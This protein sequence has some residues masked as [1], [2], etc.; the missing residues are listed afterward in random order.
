MRKVHDRVVIANR[1]HPPHK[2]ALRR[3]RFL[4]CERRPKVSQKTIQ[5]IGSRLAVAVRENRLFDSRPDQLQIH[6]VGMD[7]RGQIP[8]TAYRLIGW[9]DC[10]GTGDRRLDS[11]E[12]I[13]AG[14]D[15]VVLD[16]NLKPV[17][18]GRGAEEK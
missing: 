7:S 2:P 12:A 4:I 11:F 13:G 15:R 17:S 8:K 16:P 5:W 18:C 1:E 9:K 6:L 14:L 10:F 3:V